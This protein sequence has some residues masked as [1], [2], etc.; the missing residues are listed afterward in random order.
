M[1]QIDNLQEKNTQILSDIQNLQSIEQDLFNNL[2]QNESILSSE[3]KS[4]IVQKINEISQMRVNLYKSLNS[5]NVFYQ[6]VVHNSSDTLDEQT[7]AIGIIENQLNEAK[8]RLAVIEEEKNNKIRM[9]EINNYYGQKYGEHAQLMKIII[10]LLVPL[11]I[12]AILYNKNIIPKSV[13]MLL[14]IIIGIIGFY[15]LWSKFMSIIFRS[16]MNYQEYDWMFDAS[17]APAIQTTSTSTTDPWE[18]PSIVCIGEEC[19][20]QFST[21]DASS[22]KCIPNSSSTQTTSESFSKYTMY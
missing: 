3:Q 11:I 20:N 14:T 7:T 21:Y 8:A 17:G 4:Q 5:M 10:M 22:N 13:F 2:E 12:L 1:S 6:G 15:L 16:N 9:V 18:A 19:C